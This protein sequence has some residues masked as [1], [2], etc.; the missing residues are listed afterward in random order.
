[1]EGLV[2][3]NK[4]SVLEKIGSGG[5]ATVYRA[6]HLAFSEI[7]AI[8]VINSRLQDEDLVRRFK[9]EAIIARK[10]QHPHAVRIDDLDITEDGR[11]FIVM[12]YVEGKSLRKTLREGGPLPVAR[13]LHI[14]AQ[15]AEALEAAHELGVTHRDIKPDNIL[16][17]TQEGAPDYVKVLDF[18]IAKVR[19][20][21]IE[22]GDDYTPTQTGLV[23]GTPAYISPEQARGKM[24]KEVDGRADLYALGVVLFQML[25]G[26]L[27]FESDTSMGMILHH[28]HTPLT[29]PHR[30]RPELHIPLAVS[31]LLLKAMQKNREQRFQSAREMLEALQDPQAWAQLQPSER[32]ESDADGIMLTGVRGSENYDIVPSQ[33]GNVLALEQE[34]P[35][36]ALDAAGIRKRLARPALSQAEA[37]AEAIA[38]QRRLALLTAEAGGDHRALWTAVAMLVILSGFGAEYL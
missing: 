10:L 6:K 22:M 27:P 14:A 29:P 35:G 21:A 13:S 2:I 24:G 11:P 1:M 4:Y 38:R 7:R 9:T 33:M 19:E 25:T 31:L 26:K 16:L 28:L 18:G 20:G 23:V 36:L 32:G 8:K 30:A 12:E 15:V 5:M 17:T 3:A 37:R 34:T